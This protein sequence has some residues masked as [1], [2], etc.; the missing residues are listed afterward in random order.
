MSYLSNLP[1]ELRFIG[2]RPLKAAADVRPDG[3]PHYRNH[4][5][6]ASQNPVVSPSAS[7]QNRGRVALAGDRR[8]CC[9]RIARTPVLIDFRS[10]I[11]RRRRNLRED[12]IVEHVSVRA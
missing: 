7:V 1:R 6:A 8:I 9:R 5:V 10:G 3:R 11:Q 4:L 12:D 2:N